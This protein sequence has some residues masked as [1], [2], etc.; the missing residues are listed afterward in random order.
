MKRLG[1]VLILISL[2][3]VGAFNSVGQQKPPGPDKPNGQTDTFKLIAA[4]FALGKTIKGA[5]FSATAI[6]ETIQTLS[7]G[8]QIIHKSESAIYRDSEGRTRNEGTI[9]RIGKWAISGDAEQVVFINDP[10]TGFAYSL[11]PRSRTAY[12]YRI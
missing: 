2:M 6:T 1:T 9:D 11:T 3:H 4:K 8:N 5:P 10:V 12:K 7:D